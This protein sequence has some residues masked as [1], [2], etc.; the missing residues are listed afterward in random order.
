MVTIGH[1]RCDGSS[2]CTSRAFADR[3]FKRAGVEL[4]VFV[5]SDAA[6][7]EALPVFAL[8]GLVAQWPSSCPL[9]HSVEEREAAIELV[10]DVLFDLEQLD[11][12]LEPGPVAEGAE[13]PPDRA[14]A[15][16]WDLLSGLG[17]SP[18]M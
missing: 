7:G 5:G 14:E 3:S 8:L 10:P 15:I 17:A 2:W 11:G 9:T 6:H 12:R 13:V 16:G 1:S 4:P 18:A